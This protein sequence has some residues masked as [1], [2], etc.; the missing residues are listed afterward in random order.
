M[1]RQLLIIILLTVIV[2]FFGGRFALSKASILFIKNAPTEMVLGPVD[3]KVKIVHFVD[4]VNPASQRL[5]NKLFQLKTMDP[6]IQ[7]ITRPFVSSELSE[8]YARLALAS[9]DI[10]QYNAMTARMMRMTEVL[11]GVSVEEVLDKI[12]IN[13]DIV[14][15]RLDDPKVSLTLF[16]NKFLAQ[17]LSITATPA[18]II[19]DTVLVDQDY[20]LREYQNI[21][22][23]YKRR[24][25]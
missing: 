23:K 20:S 11:N 10:D 21:I 6:D 5:Y 14:L 12:N 7:I 16:W 18:L 4:F 9:I 15:S 22:Q 19:G 17:S 25:L 8:N 3:A 24:A 1:N 2:L 13:N